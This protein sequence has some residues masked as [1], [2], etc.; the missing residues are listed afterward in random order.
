MSWLKKWWLWFLA[1]AASVVAFVLVWT[2]RDELTPLHDEAEDERKRVEEDVARKQKEADEQYE[3]KKKALEQERREARD[4]VV[5]DLSKELE[6][7]QGDPEKVNDYL[8]SVDEE[9]R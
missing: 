4:A 9:M 6:D 2:R 5:S 7:V 1:G 3:K 8:H